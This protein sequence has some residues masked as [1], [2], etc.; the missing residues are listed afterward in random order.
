MH[1][2]VKLFANL[3][4]NLP[5]GSTGSKARL[6][7]EDGAT[8]HTLIAQL[9]IPVELAQMVLVNGEQ[10]REFDRP[11]NEGDTVSIFPPVAGGVQ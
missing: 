6:K 9:K 8:I 1:I 7:V 4:K 3:R 2:E 5:P 10:T 11:L